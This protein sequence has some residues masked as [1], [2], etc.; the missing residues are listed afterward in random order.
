MTT[1]ISGLIKAINAEVQM[2]ESEESYIYKLA[3][4]VVTYLERMFQEVKI[5]I[6]EYNFVDENEEILFFKKTKPQLFNKMIY[7]SKILNI[8]NL[9][10]TG[11]L[12][13][14]KR[15]LLYELDQLTI[16]FNKNIDF[17]KY[18]RSGDTMLDRYY[19]LRGRQRVQ[20]VIEN[21]YFE[22]DPRFSTSCDFKVT[23]ILAN[24]LLQ[25]YL[26]EE[27]QKLGQYQINPPDK[28][29]FPKS[30]ESWTRSKTDLVELIY[31]LCEADCFNYGRITLKRLTD[32][33]ENVF[34]IDLGDVYHT[35]LTIRGRNNRVQLLDEL[36]EKLIAKMN[37]D[38]QK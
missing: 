14:Q 34:N 30:K 17:Y 32:Y 19:F 5:L 24:D 6:S 33:L 22:R 25:V 13:A 16:F 28:M 29:I 15:Y 4:E 7:Y 38:D 1:E 36:K 23:N 37:K 21:F 26:N 2:M 27:L 12:H 18:Y 35:Y 3:T 31:A 20:M 8:E 10:P 11:S 9:R